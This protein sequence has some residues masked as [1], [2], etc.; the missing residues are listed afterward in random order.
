LIFTPGFSTSD[1]EN[2]HAGRGIG[3]NL[4]RARLREVKGKIGIQSKK[5]QGMTFDIQIPITGQT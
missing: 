1:D 2:I 4:V 3:L 5:G